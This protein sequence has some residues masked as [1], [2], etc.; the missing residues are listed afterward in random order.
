MG[1]AVDAYNGEGSALQAFNVNVANG[2]TETY[3]N[4][5]I[6]GRVLIHSGG[7]SGITATPFISLAIGDNDTGFNWISDGRMS[8]WANNT[9]IATWDWNG[10]YMTGGKVLESSYHKI[11]GAEAGMASGEA[12]NASFSGNN[13]NIISWYGIGFKS[14]IDNTTRIFFN[15]RDGYIG[16]R[17]QIHAEGGFFQDSS[18]KLKENIKDVTFNALDLVKQT[19]VRTFNYISDATKEERIGFIAEDTPIEL[20]G[21]SQDKFRVTDTVAVLLKAVQELAAEV[22]YLKGKLNGK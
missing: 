14:S 9:Q 19:T 3:G 16:T 15:T 17:G 2:N 13:V 4:A 11:P 21:E 7:Y 1:S 5:N 8:I 6:L 18:R 10:L 12:D 22:E 20:S